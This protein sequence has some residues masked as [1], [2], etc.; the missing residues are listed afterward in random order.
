MIKSKLIG[1]RLLLTTTVEDRASYI[2]KM[3]VHLIRSFNSIYLS[4]RSFKF[5]KQNE[6]EKYLFFPKYGNLYYISRKFF[7]FD[8]I[9]VIK[10]T[11]TI[12]NESKLMGS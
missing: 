9:I 3:C 2:F 5:N 8:M 4:G 7:E 1:K 10:R 12:S 11:K 6:A